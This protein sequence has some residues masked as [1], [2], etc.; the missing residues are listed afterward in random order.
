MIIRVVGFLIIAVSLVVVYLFETSSG[1]Q[2]AWR[3]LH[4]PA[5]VLT[6]LGP[7]GVVLLTTDGVGLKETVR[8]LRGPSASECYRQN[9][10]DVELLRR[11]GQEYY[12]KGPRVFDVNVDGISPYVRRLL[13]RLQARMSI[14]DVCVLLERER[15]GVTQRLSQSIQLLAAGVRLAPSVGMLGTILGMV[16]LLS[17]LS[18][19]SNIGSHMSL[20]LLTT[21]YGLFFSLIFWTPLQTHLERVLEARERGFDQ[22]LYWLELLEQRKP[23]Q[24]LGTDDPHVEARA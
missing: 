22:A 18:D 24:Y 5:L 6:G 17:H 19:P 11:L 9:E 14:N 1:M 20:A 23:S 15:D 7:F 12:L 21:F 16:Q 2:G 13:D 10:A 8:F 4:W 3:I